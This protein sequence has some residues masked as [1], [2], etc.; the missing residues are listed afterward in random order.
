MYK[1]L[2]TLVTV[3]SG[4][5]LSAADI[6]QFSEHEGLP[7]RQVYGLQA[8]CNGFVW[9]YTPSGIGRYDGREFRTYHLDYVDPSRD[10]IQS[11][12]ALSLT[13]DGQ[14]CISLKSGQVFVYDRTLDLFEKVFDFQ[15]RDLDN[16]RIYNVVFSDGTMALCTSDGI[17][18]LTGSGIYRPALAGKTV[19][20]LMNV[21]G[22]TWYASA[23]DGLYKIDMTVRKDNSRDFNASIIPGSEG[24]NFRSMKQSHSKIFAGSFAN[25]VYVIDND[26][27]RRL[28]FID[29]NMPVNKIARADDN[30]LLV[31]IDGAGVYRIDPQSEQ[32]IGR[33]AYNGTG[34]GLSANT[35][36]DICTDSDGGIWIGTTTHGINYIP[37]K[38]SEVSVTTHEYRNPNSLASDYVITIFE[39]S[40]GDLWYGTDRKSVV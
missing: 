36:S 6:R 17:Y 30:T 16:I 39:D 15:D 35:I 8:D 5:A 25:G 21:G 40:D 20:D 4:L 29:L 9:I 12:T 7:N 10:N 13:P 26:T 37:R 34:S 11:A 1:L 38:D 3:L 33:Y 32:I 23:D 22:K 14:L 19:Y 2:V 27:A 28:N 18:A 31:G 24:K